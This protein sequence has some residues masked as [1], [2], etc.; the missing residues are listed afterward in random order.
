MGKRQQYFPETIL[1]PR[2]NRDLGNC[3]RTE[4]PAAQIVEPDSMRADPQALHEHCQ[5]GNPNK[6]WGLT[7][8]N[9]AICWTDFSER[10]C[11]LNSRG[12]RSY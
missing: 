12:F 4:L 10:S 5:V 11:Q 3:K 9:S 2:D 6:A 8:G 1:M 7:S